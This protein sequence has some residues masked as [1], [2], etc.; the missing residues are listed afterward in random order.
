LNS[1]EYLLKKEHN[2]SM[3]LLSVGSARPNFVKIAAISHA[4]RDHSNISH[5]VVHTGQHY[6]P[7]FSSIFFEQL[8]I[9][10]PIA[11]LEVHLPSREEVI[12]ETSKKINTVLLNYKPDWV[13]VYGDVNGAV[14]AALAAKNRGIP[15]AHI[16]AGLRSHDLTMPEEHNRVEIDR[17]ADI[18]FCTEQSAVNNIYTENLLGSVE[19]VGNTMIDTLERMMPNIKN[20]NHQIIPEK[21]YILATLHRPSNVDSEETLRKNIHFFNTIAENLPII[22][23]IHHRLRASLKQFNLSNIL[24]KNIKLIDALGYTEF[25][26][27]VIHSTAI[28]TDSGGIQEEA[29]YLQKR[30]FTL[31]KNTERPITIECGSNTLIDPINYSS[32][33]KKV[34]DYLHNLNSFSS[35]IPPL[36]DGKA[37]ERIISWFLKNYVA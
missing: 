21:N 31:R 12:L 1:V 35:T 3:K 2:T 15:L 17:I 23:P 27:L 34:V 36:W 24:H 4:C 19:L 18:L 14:G 11:N 10:K 29:A 33:T 16:E 5:A 6:D 37:G 7:L 25:L 22:I 8:N 30:C 26:H 13:L 32:D 28:I 9:E 20:I